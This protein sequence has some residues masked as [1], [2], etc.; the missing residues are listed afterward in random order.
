MS[1]VEPSVCADYLQKLLTRLRVVSGDQATALLDIAACLVKN[2]D[3]DLHDLV[4][5][6]VEGVAVSDGHVQKRAYRILSI[7]N[8]HRPNLIAANHDLI[9]KVFVGC[10]VSCDPSAR[11]QRFKLLSELDISG[12]E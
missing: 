9:A 3:G 10:A 5:I 7:I 12:M 2:V 1:C 4:G 11:K 8:Q 6:A